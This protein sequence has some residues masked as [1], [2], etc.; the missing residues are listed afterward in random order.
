MTTTNGTTACQQAQQAQPLTYKIIGSFRYNDVE[1]PLV[2][3]SN[4]TMR[5]DRIALLTATNIKP[6]DNPPVRH[7]TTDT[8]RG[9]EVFTMDDALKIFNRVLDEQKFNVVRQQI[10]DAIADGVLTVVTSI[11]LLNCNVGVFASDTNIYLE[12]TDPTTVKL[13]VISNGLIWKRVAVREEQAFHKESTGLYTALHREAVIAAVSQWCA[14]GSV[15]IPTLVANGT[16][17]MRHGDAGINV[18]V[19]ETSY[20][21]ASSVYRF[22]VSHGGVPTVL[23][24]ILAKTSAGNIA[25]IPA[26]AFAHW[27]AC[28]ADRSVVKILIKIINARYDKLVGGDPAWK[29]VTVGDWWP[30][31]KPAVIQ[32]TTPTSPV[33]PPHISKLH[34]LVDKYASKNP[35]GDT[36]EQEYQRAFLREC[37]EAYNIITNNKTSFDIMYC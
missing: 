11:T 8:G 5:V 17:H 19:G 25:V 16:I 24:S 18:Y 20:L 13:P 37:G 21:D 35:I 36:T 32:P 28:H 12:V 22:I 9:C 30:N 7:I 1:I 4:D 23:G 14:T 15:K 33:T 31:T 10:S 34:A 29:P 3:A 2:A 27:Y 26:Q 6:V